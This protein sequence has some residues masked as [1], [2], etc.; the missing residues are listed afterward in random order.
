KPCVIESDKRLD[1]I[2]RGKFKWLD[3]PMTAEED[4]PSKPVKTFKSGTILPNTNPKGTEEENEDDNLEAS[5]HPT[6]AK[7]ATAVDEEDVTEEFEEAVAN[8]LK[9]SK[10]KGHGYTVRDGDK[11]L[12]EEPLRTSTQVKSFLARHCGEEKE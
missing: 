6:T 1:E 4:T 11:K 5:G 7:S 8:D 2:F 3:K 12:T 9:I 10:V